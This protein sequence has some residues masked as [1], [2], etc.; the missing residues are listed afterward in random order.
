MHVFTYLYF[1]ALQI[2]QHACEDLDLGSTKF[3]VIVG[4]E[5]VFSM[6]VPMVGAKQPVHWFLE[7]RA[8]IIQQGNW[9]MGWFA[10]RMCL[11]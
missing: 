3:K 4:G 2:E 5:C 11:L 1:G 10:L 9:C 8:A 6:Y 7:S